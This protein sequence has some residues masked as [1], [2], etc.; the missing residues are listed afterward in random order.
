[1]D[2][3]TKRCHMKEAPVRIQNKSQ[4]IPAKDMVA[5][6]LNAQF[7]GDN[8]NQAAGSFAASLLAAG[9][10]ALYAFAAK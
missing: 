5:S 9:K 1:M 4:I 7:L 2:W 8:L 6:L 3:I 10:S